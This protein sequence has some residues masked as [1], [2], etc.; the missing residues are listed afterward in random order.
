M[1]GWGRGW[2]WGYGGGHAGTPTQADAAVLQQVAQVVEHGAL[3]LAADAAEVAEEAAAVGDHFGEADLLDVGGDTGGDM[4]S[5]TPWGGGYGGSGVGGLTLVSPP[6]N[7][8]TI[9]CMTVSCIPSARIRLG[10]W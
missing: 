9:T 8:L 5:A 6:P 10:C 7:T 2:G 1:W 4:G 3:I